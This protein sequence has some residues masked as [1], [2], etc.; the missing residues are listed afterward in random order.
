MKNNKGIESILKRRSCRAYSKRKIKDE[1]LDKI[2]QCGSY[3]PSAMNKQTAS[4]LVI[5]NSKMVSKLRKLSLKVASRDCF[6]G[7]KVL[8]LV[9]GNKDEKFVIQDASCMLENLFVAASALNISSCWINQ[10]NDLLNDKNGHKIKEEL[11][12]NEN[13]MVVGTCA[14]GY[15]L[16]KKEIEPKPRVENHV[17]YLK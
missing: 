2:V 12:L 8:I 9:F 7:A 15:S 11:G 4:M 1:L 3:A 5:T 6:Y 16:D 10:V 14:L 17:R 13:D